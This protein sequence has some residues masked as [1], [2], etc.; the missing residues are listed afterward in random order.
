MKAGNLGYYLIK[1]CSKQQDVLTIRY[2]KLK[3]ILILQI[4]NYF[5]S[6]IN[7]IFTNQNS[8]FI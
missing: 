7:F 1:I 4:L 8:K 6:N 2:D 3:N 5:E